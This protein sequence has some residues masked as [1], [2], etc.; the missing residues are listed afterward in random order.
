MPCHD[1]D[2]ATLVRGS[3]HE[4]EPQPKVRLTGLLLSPLQTVMKMFE[5]KIYVYL[6]DL[7]AIGLDKSMT[8][9]RRWQTKGGY[10]HSSGSK[11]KGTDK[12]KWIDN[13]NPFPPFVKAG[14]FRQSRNAL[15]PDLL[16]EWLIKEGHTPE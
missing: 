14:R 11:E 13:P 16:I 9:L 6:E 10:W 3:K 8:T 4:T 7:H 12:K 15:R 1:D 2:V 5:G